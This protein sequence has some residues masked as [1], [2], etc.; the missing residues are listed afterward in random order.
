M[1]LRATTPR[2]YVVRTSWVI[3]EGSN[4]VRTMASLAEKGVSPAVV[5]DQ[6]GR[7]T[8]TT[9]LADA[10]AHLVG[11]EAPYGTY[12]V[13]NAGDVL[14]WQQFAAEVF[15]LSGR[16]RDDVAP[17]ST[18]EYFAGALAAGKPISPRPLNSA[19]SLEKLRSTG[20]EPVDQLE[21]LR[22]YLA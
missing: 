14:S 3:G 8:F 1:E 20:F 15:V 4:F 2:H 5:S 6:V 9:T 7:L 22:A 16:L 12:N 17:T 11:S 21:A 10:I 13:S 18:E 19:L